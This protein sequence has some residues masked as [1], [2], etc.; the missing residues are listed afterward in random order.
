MMDSDA[1]MRMIWMQ[2]TIHVYVTVQTFTINSIHYIHIQNIC[3]INEKFRR[4]QTNREIITPENQQPENSKFT[5]ILTITYMYYQKT[6]KHIFF[7]ATYKYK[8]KYYICSRYILFQN[9]HY[10][11]TSRTK[12]YHVFALKYIGTNF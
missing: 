1:T 6:G 11:S 4:R 10:V 5:Q 3:G 7:M 12:L 9:R 2:R 8:G